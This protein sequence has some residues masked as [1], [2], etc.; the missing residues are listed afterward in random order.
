MMDASAKPV[1]YDF[2]LNLP[3]TRVFRVSDHVMPRP[4]ILKLAYFMY[5]IFQNNLIYLKLQVGQTSFT[6]Q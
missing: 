6:P 2:I 4:S 5:Y 3:V 1:H